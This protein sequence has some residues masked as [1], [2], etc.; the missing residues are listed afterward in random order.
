[1][2][3]ESSPILEPDIEPDR[4]SKPTMYSSPVAHLLIK[5]S[6]QKMKLLTHR[7][8]WSALVLSVV[9]GAFLCA[10]RLGTKSQAQEK[11]QL[12]ARTGYVSDFAHVVDDSTRQRLDAVLDNL[13]KRSGIELNLATV[14]ST[15]NQ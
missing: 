10:G 7:N 1:M 14:Q 4:N 8:L 5:L 12:P 11:T 15:G 2:P 6:G 9:A 13:K 3:G